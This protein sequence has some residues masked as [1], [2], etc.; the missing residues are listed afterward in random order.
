MSRHNS[1]TYGGSVFAYT[2]NSLVE[3]LDCSFQV[4]GATHYGGAIYT[5]GRKLVIKSS[6][7][8]YN[9]VLCEYINQTYG[10]AV[11]TL[12]NDVAEVI[13]C[14][15]KGNKV[16][17]YGGA[18]F[19]QGKKLLIKSSLFEYNTPVS[20]FNLE[21]HG[22][23]VFG[24][25]YYN[26]VVEILN[27][28]F[29]RN[30]VTFS[31][32]AIRTEG[33]QLVVKSSFFAYNTALS[34]YAAKTTG[35]AVFAYTCSIVQIQNCSFRGNKALYVGGAIYTVGM[36]LTVKWS[37]FEYNSACENYTA[38]GILSGFGGA[39]SHLDKP[40]NFKVS[41]FKSSSAGGLNDTSSNCLAK[42]HGGAVYSLGVKLTLKAL[43][44][45]NNS[46]GGAGGAISLLAEGGS[47]FLLRDSISGCFFSHNKAIIV[48]GSAV[49]NVGRELLTKNSRFQNNL[50]LGSSGEG[51]AL[52][53]TSLL[54]SNLTQ[55]HI[56]YCIF[57]GNYASFC[58]GAIMATTNRLFINSSF[59]SSSYPQSQSYSGGDFLYSRSNVLLQNISFFDVD[60]YNH[61]NSL[62]VHENYFLFNRNYMIRV[63]NFIF[64]LE[65]AVHLKC[66]TGKNIVVSNHSFQTPPKQFTFI[67]VSCSFCSDNPYSL[68]TNHLDLFSHDD[69]IK[70]TNAK[71]YR[72]PL[73]GVCEKGK[74]RA[75]N[76]FWGYDIGKEVHFSF[77]P[78]GYCCYQK[79][80]VDYSSCHPGRT[81]PLCGQCEEG[82]TENFMTPDCLAYEECYHPWYWLVVIICGIMYVIVFMYPTEITKSLKSLLVPAFISELFKYSIK[83]RIKISEIFKDMLQFTKKSFL[84]NLVRALKHS[85]LQIMSLY[86][87]KIMENKL[88]G[89]R[90]I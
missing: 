84:M 43:L 30:E 35:G 22:G 8:E 46:A 9:T 81:G 52:F 24:N 25:N 65:A 26:A 80:C 45:H 66:L 15:F 67:S 71:C 82:L 56:F 39:I 21:T 60:K 5:Q 55:T 63:M 27:C 70:R 3:I 75:A 64:T 10:G 58:G 33:R 78:F 38:C 14:W 47:A 83:T 72:C 36:R 2:T 90:A 88:K 37:L 41:P 89:C 79:E 34:K 31:G 76:S 20:K 85:T 19:N 48:N 28:T 18:I 53:T 87:K 42:Q 61:R 74:I 44:F 50:V 17:F 57:N 73:G 11:A 12:N 40:Q 32:G 1:K 68:Y 59:M 86:R 6:L 4:N 54:L 51:E 62:I 69:S 29:E 49:N 23:A 77:C 7:F 16:T 13:N